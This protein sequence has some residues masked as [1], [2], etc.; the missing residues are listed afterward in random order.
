MY[1]HKMVFALLDNYYLQFL[2]TATEPV[3][4]IDARL[5]TDNFN[6]CSPVYFSSADF[7]II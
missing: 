5:V 3:K 6:L 2:K 4:V 1:Y 7:V